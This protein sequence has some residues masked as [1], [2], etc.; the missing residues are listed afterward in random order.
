MKALILH[1][2]FPLIIPDMAA[3]QLRHLAIQGMPFEV[4]GAIYK[5]NIIVQHQNVHPEP[6]HHYDAEIDLEE[7]KAIW[8]SHPVGPIGPSDND[9]RFMQFCAEQGLSFHHI[10]V[11]TKE[12]HEYRAEIFDASASA[13]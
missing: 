11:T 4:C 6:E 12:V 7:V 13:A 8:H 3:D 9:L 1:E 2:V 5:H 10:I